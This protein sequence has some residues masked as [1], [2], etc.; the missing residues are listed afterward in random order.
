M[1]SG[2]SVFANPGNRHERGGG[3][4]DG[5]HCS[6]CVSSF[7][8]GGQDNQ[9]Q[10]RT[11][12]VWST[13]LT[14]GM[15]SVRVAECVLRRCSNAPTYRLQRRASSQIT[16]LAQPR[17]ERSRPR[18]QP[19][20]VVKGF[21]TARR[22]LRAGIQHSG[23]SIRRPMSS[24]PTHDK[25]GWELPDDWDFSPPPPPPDWLIVGPRDEVSIDHTAVLCTATQLRVHW[26]ALYTVSPVFGDLRVA[27]VDAHMTPSPRYTSHFYGS[28]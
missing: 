6:H 4:T 10:R 5:Q 7:L 21:H 14:K 24:Q 11:I 8:F 1:P 22:S 3:G 2:G 15:S 9:L 28:L 18:L 23:S 12:A 27:C 16:M 25:D 17:A 20:T 19:Q 26:H 13:L